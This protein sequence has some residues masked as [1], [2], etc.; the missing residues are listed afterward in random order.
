MQETISDLVMEQQL[1]W[2]G[3]VG[4]MNEERLPK[5]VL[6][7]E[8]RKKRPHHG[9]KK[10]WR[11]VAR[12]NVEAIGV[13]ER[14]YSLCQDR[15]IW[16]RMCCEGVEKVSKTRQENTC[17][18]NYRAQTCKFICDCGRSFRRQGD[19]TRHKRYCSHRD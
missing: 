12:S 10:R 6:F 16:F 4:R 14:W 9:V 8:V 2:L 17:P 7:G 18:A 5:R 15:K 1:R 13:S 3:H 19:L 11:D